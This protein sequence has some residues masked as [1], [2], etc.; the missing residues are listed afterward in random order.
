M[1]QDLLQFQTCQT[2]S[3]SKTKS[4][5]RDILKSP[6]LMPWGTLIKIAHFSEILLSHD[7]LLGHKWY[8]QPWTKRPTFQNNPH[9][10][11]RCFNLEGHLWHASLPGADKSWKKV[12]KW[13]KKRKWLSYHALENFDQSKQKKAKFKKMLKKIMINTN[14]FFS[15]KELLF[16]LGNC[17]WNEK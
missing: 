6:W 9:T 11:K 2:F 3:M 16:S 14:N 10:K 4:Q 17:I 12:K 13:T 8:K 1:H 5:D 7:P 15:C